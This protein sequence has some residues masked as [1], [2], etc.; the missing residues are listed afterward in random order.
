MIASKTTH[1]ASTWNGSV[2]TER[3]GIYVYGSI[4]KP[5]R[6]LVEISHIDG[7]RQYYSTP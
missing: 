7:H 3:A 5:I 1:E 4:R 6:L 2:I